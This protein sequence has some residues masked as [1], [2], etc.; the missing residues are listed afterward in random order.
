MTWP[1][2]AEYRDT[3]GDW[4]GR[5][6]ASWSIERMSWLFGDI[7]SGTTPET[8]NPD[9]YGGDINWVTTG[10]LRERAVRRTLKRITP[11]ALAAHTALRIYPAGTLLIAMYG[12]TIGRLG[13][14]EEPACTNQACCAFAIPGRIDSRFAYYTLSA[15]R[16]HLIQLASG[17]GQPNINQDKLRKLRVAVPSPAEQRIVVAFLDA[18]TA[19][20]D[21][22]IAKQE[23]LIATLREDRTATIYQAVTKGL[24]PPATMK[25]SGANWIGQVPTHWVVGKVKHGFLVTL[26]KMYQG[27]RQSPTDKLLPH[28]KAGSLTKAR[29]L[30]LDH[31]ML[32]WFSPDEVRKL[33]V[34]KDDLLVVEGGATYGRCAIVAQDL[35]AWGFQKSLNRVRANGNNSIRFL[36][37]LIQAATEI[38]HVSVLCGRAT[39]PHFTAEKLEA[40]EW[41]H[42]SAA[43]QIEIVDFLDRRCSEIET[44]IAKATQVTKKLQEYRSALI[45]DAVTGKIDVRGAA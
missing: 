19:K 14:L 10:E 23:H 17:G 39:I 15:A 31:P 21:A 7:S 35:P 38:G 37:Y 32:C 1:S 33:S 40:L 45:T 44:L 9:F 43:E 12:A 41:P 25:N 27:E 8:G 5:T 42:P 13:W 22:L 30:D 11:S 24:C 6:P 2:Y 34:Q 4:L 18:E 26:G 16:E 36:S 29:E 20:I 3:D 28:L